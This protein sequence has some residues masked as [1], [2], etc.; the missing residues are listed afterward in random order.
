[1]GKNGGSESLTK[2][3]Q[4]LWMPKL[5]KDGDFESQAEQWLWM[6]NWKKMTT[7]NARNMTLNT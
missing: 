6:L 3:E 7:L 5:K 2:Y 1:M 4:R